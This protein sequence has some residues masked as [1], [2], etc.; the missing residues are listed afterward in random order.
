MLKCVPPPRRDWTKLFCLQYIENCLRLSRT[1]FTPPTR[2]VS[3]SAVWTSHKTA[4]WPASCRDCRLHWISVKDTSRQC[5]S[6]NFTV[7][8]WP[9][10]HMSDEAG[11]LYHS[12]T[13]L[14]FCLFVRSAIIGHLSP[15]IHW[16]WLLSCCS[17]RS[18]RPL[19]SF[20]HVCLVPSTPSSFSSISSS[21]SIFLSL[22]SFPSCSWVSLF[23]W[24]TA[25]WS[26][27]RRTSFQLICIVKMCERLIV[28]SAFCYTAGSGEL[29]YQARPTGEKTVHDD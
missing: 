1:Q 2:Q 22:D 29:G 16:T 21:R 4:W 26:R 15:S 20:I 8:R 7:C 27:K 14:D 9:Q 5:G 13:W 17:Q 12:Y 28:W 10:A 11:H 23:L 3:A 24:K 6:Y 19:V 25:C 18:H